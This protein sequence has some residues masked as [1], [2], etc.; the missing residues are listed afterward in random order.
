MKTYLIVASLLL[1]AF[2]FTDVRAH[3]NGL[4]KT[5]PMGW[6][7]WNKF[8]C[9]VSEK[10]IK[11]MAD[12]MVT[13]GMRDAGYIYLVI[14]DCWQIDRDA[15]GNIM[16]DPKRFPSGMKALANYVHSKGLKVGLYSDAGTLTCQ[17]R[18]GSRGYEFQ[19]ARQYAAWDVDYLKYDWCST[20]TQNAPAADSIMRDALLK[21]GR[22]IVFSIFEWGTAEPSLRGKAVGTPKP[23]LWA[24]DVGNLW[25]TTGDI[26]DCWDCKRDW[27]GIGVVHILDL[28]DGLESHAGPGHWNDTD[29]LEV[30]NGGMTTT[31]YRAHFS[32]WCLLSAPLMAGNDLRS[33]SP[34]IKEILTNREV[35]AVDQD[36]LGLQGRRVKRGG[37]REVWMKQ[38]ADGGRAV[39]LFNRGPK[40]AELSLSWTDIGYPPHLSARVRD[41]WTGKDLGQFSSTFSTEVPSHGVVMFPVRP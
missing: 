34:E 20:S 17:K 7:S 24:K 33:M 40:A 13:S 4:A 25:R 36:P 29:M 41:L 16:P 23:W 14:D 27:G 30:G 39:V 26:Q 10:L 38:L 5:P 21:A 15:Q 6:N 32:L 31:E 11:E 1:V 35:I 19:D 2:C 12:A 9:N 18:P 8:A 37:D 28:Q 22:P 3:D